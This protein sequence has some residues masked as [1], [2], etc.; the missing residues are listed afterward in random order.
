MKRAFLFFLSPA[1]EVPRLSFFLTQ[2]SLIILLLWLLPYFLRFVDRDVGMPL[3]L[4]VWGASIWSSIALF[5]K[6]ARGADRSP[7][8]ALTIL[9]PV[10]YIIGLLILSVQNRKKPKIEAAFVFE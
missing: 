4:I 5:I 1:G 8:L 6:R 7:W 3:A 2:C 10:F 9:T